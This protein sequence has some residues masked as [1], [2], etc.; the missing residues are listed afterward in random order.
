MTLNNITLLI[1]IVGSA[2]LTVFFG[3]FPDIWTFVTETLDDN[4]VLASGIVA[5]FLGYCIYLIHFRRP[6]AED[7]VQSQ[8]NS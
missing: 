4:L 1:I 6:L 3:I 2:S 5:S 7:D 8:D